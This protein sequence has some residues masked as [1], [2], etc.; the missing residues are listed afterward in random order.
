MVLSI[1]RA[2][3]GSG[4]QTGT[5]VLIM[6]FHRGLILPDLRKE[7]D[8]SFEVEHGHEAEAMLV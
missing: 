2:M 1:W 8:M 5:A 7:I 3:F 4:S 6:R